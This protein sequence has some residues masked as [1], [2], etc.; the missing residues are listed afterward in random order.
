VLRVACYGYVKKDSG[1]VSGANFLILEELLKR[2][3]QIDFFGNENFNYLTELQKYKIFRFI[4]LPN[5]SFF[6]RSIKQVLPKQVH[7]LFDRTLGGLIDN[8]YSINRDNRIMQSAIG[9]EHI[10]KPYNLALSLGLYSPFGIADVPIISWAQGTPNTEWLYIK[11]LRQ[12]IVQYCGWLPY[13]QFKFFYMLKNPR[14]RAA[15]KHSDLYI[16]GSQWSR[17][18]MIAY[19]LNGSAVK[20]LPY[21]IDLNR[22]NPGSEKLAGESR[23]TFLW[24]GR[25][26]PRKRLDLLMEAYALL[27]K[28]RQDVHLKIIGSLRHT[29]GYKT[30][31]DTFDFPEY[32]EYQPSVE[33]KNIPD[34]IRSCS[35][36]IQT[37][38]GEN[39]GSAIAEALCCGIP[40][41]LG[42]TNG[43]RE[44]TSPSCCF[45]FEHYTPENI[46]E[47]MNKALNTIEQSSVEIAMEA[48][49]TAEKN[50]STV[51]VVDDLEA[52]FKDAISQ[53]AIPKSMRSNLVE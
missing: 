8:L 34:L 43:T 48:R 32:V 46:K 39:F 49:K 3:V 9:V 5:K 50:F 10:Q 33:Q 16:C 24:L 45:M 27:L 31:I 30:L 35:V 29:Q 6:R 28:D 25:I 18:K 42:S 36:V 20:V 37:S 11:K 38:E 47:K 14:L 1:S 17:Q 19:G 23:K 52:I 26:D 44:F 21:P 13:L 2:E 7:K 51:K 12:Q 40:V 41:L 53:A 4:E 15:L 22:F